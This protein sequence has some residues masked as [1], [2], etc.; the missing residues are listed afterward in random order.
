MK[1][2]SSSVIYIALTTKN[3]GSLQPCGVHE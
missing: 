2:S 3:A 1:S